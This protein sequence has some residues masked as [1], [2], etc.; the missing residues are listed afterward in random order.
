M[1]RKEGKQTRANNNEKKARRRRAHKTGANLS[2]QIHHPLKNK[3]ETIK[4]NSNNNKNE[5]TNKQTKLFDCLFVCLFVCFRHLG[6]HDEGAREVQ[7]HPLCVR[8]LDR[9]SVHLYC[10]C[11]CFTQFIYS[12]FICLLDLY[13]LNLYVALLDF[14][15]VTFVLVFIY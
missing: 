13:F 14:A 8:E 2:K 3:S 11:C 6:V 4:Q 12:L 10:C 5:Q 1:Q 15:C 9:P 7:L